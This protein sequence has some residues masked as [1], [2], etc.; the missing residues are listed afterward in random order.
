MP[1]I[2]FRTNSQLDFARLCCE[3]ECFNHALDPFRRDFE[4]LMFGQEAAGGMIGI[5]GRQD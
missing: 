4:P 1:W 3:A 2:G 5:C